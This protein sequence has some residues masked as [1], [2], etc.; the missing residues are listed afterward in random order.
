[1]DIQP[2]GEA[3]FC[4]DFPDYSFGNAKGSGI[5]EVWN[6]RESESFRVYRRQHS[7]AICYRCG[8]KSISEITE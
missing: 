3:N 7:L 2:N 8:A 6:S 1:M 5:E 4:V